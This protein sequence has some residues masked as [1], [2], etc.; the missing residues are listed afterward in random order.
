MTELTGMTLA[1]VKAWCGEQ[2]L[3]GFRAG[4]IFGWM[5]RG[6]DWEEMTM[7]EPPSAITLPNSS[8]RTE[9]P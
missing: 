7:P 6:A 2:G 1:E 3:P 8:S 5:H 4:Q 9:V